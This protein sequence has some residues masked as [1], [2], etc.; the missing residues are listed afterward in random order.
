ML[1]LLV[2]PFVALAVLTYVSAVAIAGDEQDKPVYAQG[3]AGLEGASP[4]HDD[5]GEATET[6]GETRTPT[7]DDESEGNDADDETADDESSESETDEEAAEH[8]DGDG[9]TRE[10][11]RRRARRQPTATTN[12]TGLQ[13]PAIPTCRPL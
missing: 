10:R 6:D 12:P 11:P 2:V 8:D 5:E 9:A 4:L 7:A 1:A 3:Q 13:K